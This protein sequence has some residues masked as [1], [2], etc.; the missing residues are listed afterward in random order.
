MLVRD[1]IYWRI[2]PHRRALLHRAIGEALER[3]YA[4]EPEKQL[5]ELAHHFLCCADAGSAKKAIQYA[6]AA[7]DAALLQLGFED[8]VRLYGAALGVLEGAPTADPEHVVRLLL[9][10]GAAQDRA[11]DGA[12]AVLTFRRAAAI[13]RHLDSAELMAR[14]A[15]GIGLRFGQI[16]HV[17]YYD[18]EQLDTLQVALASTDLPVSLRSRLLARL[19]S[20]I[21]LLGERDRA[22]A[23]SDEAMQLARASND[24]EAL[25]EAIKASYLVSP[26]SPSSGGHH[27]FVTELREI[28]GR[29]GRHDHLVQSH[30]I[31]TSD[32]FV[33]ATDS[34]ALT[35][36]V[37]R[38]WRAA[39]QVREPAA[40]WWALGLQAALHFLTGRA[41]EGMAAAKAAHA[42]GSRAGSEMVDLSLGAHSF[43]HGWLTGDWSAVE[44]TMRDLSL[45]SPRNSA[46]KVVHLWSRWMLGER[47]AVRGEFE[48]WVDDRRPE[49]RGRCRRG[50]LRLGAALSRPARGRPRELG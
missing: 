41:D 31:A 39:E 27:R 33:R 14:A 32:A 50:V 19:A 38:T 49:R 25:F 18:V 46:L 20:E 2:E 4:L 47:D 28:A 34:V 1:A 43:S 26:S 17:G 29:T 6:E 13:A 40:R 15:L 9:A 22:L 5:A 35:A 24:L 30:V 36:E 44:A 42:L 7:A 16:F 11:G 23:H 45:R 21:F 10:R 37:Q 48:D 3:R 8:A 12:G